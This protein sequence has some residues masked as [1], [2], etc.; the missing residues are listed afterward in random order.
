LCGSAS[1][2]EETIA[3]FRAFHGAE[4]PFV[5][6]SLPSLLP[7]GTGYVPA[8]DEVQLSDLML[9]YWARVAATRNPNG[10]GALTWLPYPANAQTTDPA[11]VLD[12]QPYMDSIG[13]HVAQCDY[14]RTLYP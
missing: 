1:P 6:A 10:G 12:V 5:F 13:Y 8:N 11:L 3:Q 4:L 14:L 2:D 7:W 9:G